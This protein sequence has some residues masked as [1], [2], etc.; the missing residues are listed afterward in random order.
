[1]HCILQKGRAH[2]YTQCMW[3]E[4][5]IFLARLLV[6][7]VLLLAGLAKLKSPAS[8]FLKAILGYDMLPQW[9]AMVVAR[10]LPWLEVVTGG[11]L[12][13]GLWSRVAAT[14][15]A[16]LLL[17]FSSAIVISLLRGKDQD[18]GCFRSVTPVQWWLIYRNLTLMGALLPVYAL[19]GGAWAVDGWLTPPASNP[20]QLSTGL[21]FLITVWILALGATLL[22]HLWSRSKSVS[23]Q[24]QS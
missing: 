3:I 22:M 19:S 5:G 12:V 9:S 21:A 6:G 20:F 16:G 14:F 1:M 18:C 24:S 15:G 2:R 8:Q 7:G 4:A 23:F 10:V 13:I 17:V 11:L